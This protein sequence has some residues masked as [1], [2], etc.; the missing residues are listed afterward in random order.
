MAKA[1][2]KKIQGSA[3]FQAVIVS[4][5]IQGNCMGLIFGFIGQ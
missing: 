4:I 3:P 5:L 2:E 1:M